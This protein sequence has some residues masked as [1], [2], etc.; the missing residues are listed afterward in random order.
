MSN[1]PGFVWYDLMTT[2]LE[3]AESF[4]TRLLGWGTQ[5]FEGGSMPYTMWTAGGEPIG[6]LMDLPEQARA[7]GA[8]PNWMAYVMVENLGASSRRVVELGGRVEVPPT[9]IPGAG[10]FAV[11]ADPQGA[12]LGLYQSRE[13]VA[14]CETPSG[15][16]R[17][18]WHELATSDLE[19]GFRFYAELF[20][21]GV[22]EDMD[23]GPAGVYRL[24][25]PEGCMP[26]GG[27]FTKPAEMPGPPC[28]VYYITVGDLDEAVAQVAT[29]GGAVVHGPMEVPGGDRIAQCTDPQGALFALHW[30][31]PAAQGG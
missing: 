6:G 29:L 11:I 8:P 20:G 1:E 22:V 7:A 28:W 15:P 17:F 9:D 3:S 31:N 14:G 30:R 23:M 12:V 27:M 10:A 16:G 18:S 4:Y 24:Y 25:G 5:P 26:L 21:W 13:P 19:G 2:D